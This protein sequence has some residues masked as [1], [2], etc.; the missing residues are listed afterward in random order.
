MESHCSFGI[1]DLHHRPI[2]PSSKA[3]I[4]H[5]QK[6]REKIKSLQGRYRLLNLDAEKLECEK[7]LEALSKLHF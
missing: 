1:S 6:T 4:R 5:I 2:I 7:R 3:Y